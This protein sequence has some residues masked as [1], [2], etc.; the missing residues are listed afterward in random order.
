MDLSGVESAFPLPVWRARG[1]ELICSFLTAARTQFCVFLTGPPS[2][3]DAC[4]KDP[5]GAAD[6]QTSAQLQTHPHL[7]A[8][9]AAAH[10]E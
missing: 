3:V 9:A 10:S 5:L 1:E 6:S 7:T 8:A 2:S 4:A